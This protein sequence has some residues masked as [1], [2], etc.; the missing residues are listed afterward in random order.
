M[1]SI[2]DKI[3]YINEEN[4]N[5]RF[6]ISAMT[7]NP[8]TWQISKVEDM[9]MG[10]FGLMRLTFVQVAFNKSVDYIDY[11]AT[12]PDG[13]K[14]V[15]A[16]YADYYISTSPITSIIS[17]G[18][19]STS[20]I[21]SLNSSTGTIK[22]GGSYRT[23]TAQFF[24][25]N[26]VDVTSKYINF[27]STENWSFYIDELDVTKSGLIAV[28]PHKDANKIKFKFAKEYEYLSKMLVVKCVVK[29]VVGELF[30]EIVSL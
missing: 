14:D 7:S 21:C 11:N 9:L 5:Q 8:R 3:F 19:T 4:Q 24:D 13:S 30:M 6:I 23:I 18:S 17:N 27:I 29:G 25:A 20:N 22:V 15:Y 28:L 16:M 2:T 26:G 10:E 12:N 1:N